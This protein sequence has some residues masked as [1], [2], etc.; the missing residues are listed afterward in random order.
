MS[1]AGLLAGAALALAAA[2]PP[3]PP[4]V[5]GSA[6]ADTV[7]IRA[8]KV[9]GTALINVA[10]GNSNQQANAGVLASS[11]GHSRALITVGQE[12][13]DSPDSAGGVATKIDSDSFAGSA[14]WLAINGAAGSGNQ[15]ANI[16]TIAIGMT[17]AALSD[18]ALSQARASHEP[19]GNPDEEGVA[20]ERSVAIGSGAFANS[21]GLVQVSLIGGDRN[22]SANT[23]A[24]SATGGAKP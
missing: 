14:G 16:A 20:H 9:T 19:T 24:L 6:F 11:Q 17:G 2:S 13:G 23:F 3:P 12:A 1:R 4:P 18:T 7:D 10:A 15:Q 5:S 22:S 8:G 21:T